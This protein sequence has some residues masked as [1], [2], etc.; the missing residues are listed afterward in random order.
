MKLQFPPT[1]PKT[2]INEIMQNTEP[3][4]THWSDKYLIPLNACNSAVRTARK[5]ATP[6]E[7]WEAWKQ[8]NQMLWILLRTET[9]R[10]KSLYCLCKIVEQV[11]T[12]FTKRFPQDKRP[13]NAIEAARRC[14]DNPSQ[15]NRAAAYAAA[16]A[17]ED[18][19]GVYPEAEDAEYA[20]DYEYTDD[21]ADA[22]L[23]ASNVAYAAAVA[24]D[25]AATDPI[26]AAA[27]AAASAAY[28]AARA[29]SSTP[30]WDVDDDYGAE[31][32]VQADIVREYF[33]MA[34]IP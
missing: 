4:K 26:V 2:L 33:P 23:A 21:T 17:A 32:K 27:N 20:D 5:Y 22:A 34:P 10:A 18:A 6:Q 19:S 9:D 1:F 13:Q 11:L 29:A 25:P 31:L 30:F 3:Q 24:F 12:L 15:A 16:E 28:T 7:A 14:A 8:G